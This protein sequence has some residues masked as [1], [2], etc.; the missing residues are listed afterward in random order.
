MIVNL[1]AQLR[2]DTNGI[3]YTCALPPALAEIRR[4]EADSWNLINSPG[5]GGEA[6]WKW[7]AVRRN[8]ERI[9]E[10]RNS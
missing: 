6:A 3:V 10:L 9:E 1:L 7:H 5:Y 2:G 8:R 4:L